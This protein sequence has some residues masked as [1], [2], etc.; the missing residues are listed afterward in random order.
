MILGRLL[1][2]SVGLS[3][4]LDSVRR[5]SELVV[6]TDTSATGSLPFVRNQEKGVLAK[7]VFAEIRTVVYVLY[8]LQHGTQCAH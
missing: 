2:G 6:H 1:I 5:L 4:I 7:G 8:V 3:S